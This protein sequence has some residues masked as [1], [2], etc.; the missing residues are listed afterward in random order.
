MLAPHLGHLVP[1]ENLAELPLFAADGTTTPLQ[2][3]QNRPMPE[4]SDESLKSSID[5]T[6]L[7]FGHSF[8][9]PLCKFSIVS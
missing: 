8:M 6:S 5:L 9:S 3:L 1:D 2:D 7:H 4:L